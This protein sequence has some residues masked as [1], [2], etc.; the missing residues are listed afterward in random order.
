MPTRSR[1]RTPPTITA[2]RPQPAPTRTCRHATPKEYDVSSGAMSPEAQA[3]LASRKWRLGASTWLLS[4]IFAFGLGTGISFVYVGVRA[5]RRD[6]WLAGIVYFVVTVVA[7]I[8]T[9]NAKLD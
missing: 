8:I 4:P 6:W 1:A 3:L 2:R 5:K 9:S 7:L